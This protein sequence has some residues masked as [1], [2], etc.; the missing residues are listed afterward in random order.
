MHYPARPEFRGQAAR[1]APDSAKQI[2]GA[3]RLP[4]ARRSWLKIWLPSRLAG[5]AS[6]LHA[7]FLHQ[8]LS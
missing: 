7:G 5:D 2:P 1:W 4:L 8:G 6:T 3:I